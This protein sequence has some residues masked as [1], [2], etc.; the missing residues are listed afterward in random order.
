MINVI[1][2]KVKEVTMDI[3]N[4][5]DSLI[6]KEASRQPILKTP[7]MTVMQTRSISPEGTEGQYIVMDAPDWV[8]TVP[9]MDDSFLMVKQWRHGEQ[10]LSIEFPGGVINPG[11][12]PDK[13]AVRELKEE[14]GFTAGQLIHLGSINPNPALMSN[15]V[16]IYAALNLAKGSGQQLDSDEYINYIKLPQHEVIQKMGTPEYPHALMSAALF[17]YQRYTGTAR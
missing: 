7:V 14:T 6:W 9:V 8:V 13:A 2:S 10:K 12:D 3:K 15:H 1:D 16:H 11:E 17:L 4:S 5:D